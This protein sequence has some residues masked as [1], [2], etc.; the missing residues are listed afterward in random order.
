MNPDQLLFE[1]S[2]SGRRTLRLGSLD[3]PEPDLARLPKGS[4]RAARPHL[5]EIGELD[6]VRHYTRLSKKNLSIADSFYFTDAVV[7]ED[8]GQHTGV[9][10]TEQEE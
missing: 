4:L 10:T 6:L 8:V 5:P 7:R 2:S 3:V 9:F 1:K